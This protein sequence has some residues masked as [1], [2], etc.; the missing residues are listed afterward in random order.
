MQ[1]VGASVAAA[2]SDGSGA[3]RH[4][5]AWEQSAGKKLN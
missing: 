3:P 1:I 2:V 4:C 5:R